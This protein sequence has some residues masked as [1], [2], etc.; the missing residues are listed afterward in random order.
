MKLAIYILQAAAYCVLLLY[1]GLVVTVAISVIFGCHSIA[2]KKP[3][4]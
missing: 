2:E 1:L 4:P 3:T